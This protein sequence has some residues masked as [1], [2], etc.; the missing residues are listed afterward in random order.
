MVFDENDSGPFYLSD[1]EREASRLD[2]ETGVV[3]TLDIV[4]ADLQKELIAKGVSAHGT[5]K[6]LVSICERNNIPVRRTIPM[7]QEGWVGKPKGMLQILWER[8]F[9]DTAAKTPQEAAEFYTVNGRKDAF[10]NILENTSLKKLMQRLTD[11]IEEETLLQYHGRLQGA[12]VDRTPKCHPEMAGEGIEYSWGCAKGMY[13]RLPFKCKR[14]KNKFRE[15]VKKSMDTTNVLTIERQ[16]RFS[17]RARQYMLAYRSI[18]V[19]KEENNES[20]VAGEVTTKTTTNPL[21]EKKPPSMSAYL[22]E[23]IIKKFK[24]KANKYSS[25]RAADVYDAGYI[26]SVLKEMK[27]VTTR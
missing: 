22:V 27:M 19:K 8:G 25:H 23:T 20:T 5:R 24:A 18:A 15:S 21:A 13:R 11:F 16:R 1:E 3:R 7:I 26:N 14:N 2:R 17:K 4:K 6:Q 12:I 10:G 9:I